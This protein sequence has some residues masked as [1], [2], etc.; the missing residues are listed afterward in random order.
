MS[1]DTIEAG[2]RPPGTGT[3]DGDGAVIVQLLRD[4]TRGPGGEVLVREG[5][6]RQAAYRVRVR[7]LMV[8]M[9]CR[10][11]WVVNNVEYLALM[12]DRVAEGY[13]LAPRQDCKPWAGDPEKL[14][15]INGGKP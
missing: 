13:V 5:S 1:A 4:Q 10:A 12:D 11:V 7:A 14:P 2:T 3:G 8:A 15:E 6:I 9:G